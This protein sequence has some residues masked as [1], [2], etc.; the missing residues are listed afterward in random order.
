VYRKFFNRDAYFD[1]IEWTDWESVV[2]G[3][4][5]RFRRW[6]F[7]PLTGGHSSYLD[8]CALCALVDILSLYQSQAEWHSP[9]T[10]KEFLRKLDPVFRKK[11]PE[12]ITTTRFQGGVW[13]QVLVRDVADVFYVGVRCSLH[14]HGDLASFA[15][16]SGTAQL[17]R[18]IEDAGTSTDG[19]QRY[20]MVVFDPSVLKAHL[21]AWLSSYCSDLRRSPFGPASKAF[22]AR[23]Y[24]DFGI[25]IR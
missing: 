10:Y 5:A 8:L 23:F 11:L 12:A 17:A 9:A 19:A 13:H 18:V 16:M 14:H 6:W 4:E 24:N 3:F 25:V 1:Q 20:S 15:G 22:R 7:E 21:E 2:D